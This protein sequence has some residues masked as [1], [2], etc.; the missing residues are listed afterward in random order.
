MKQLHLDILIHCS[1][2]G[3]TWNDLRTKHGT[4]ASLVRSALAALTDRGY[5]SADK[6]EDDYVYESTRSGDDYLMARLTQL[7]KWS[8]ELY[9]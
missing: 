8:T 4:T 3:A 1:L 7:L 2:T 6:S 9:Q 5:I